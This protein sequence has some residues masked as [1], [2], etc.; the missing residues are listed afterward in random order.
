MC[1]RGNKSHETARQLADALE[2]ILPRTGSSADLN[3][4][5]NG[6]N[7]EDK[8]AVLVRDVAGGLQA[9]SEQV[10]NRFPTY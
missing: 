7:V 6:D 9:W 3:S 8:V 5:V 1:H 2:R 10:D 4:L